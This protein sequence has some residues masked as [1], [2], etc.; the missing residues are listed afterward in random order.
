MAAPSVSIDLG[1]SFDFIT[2]PNFTAA[3]TSRILGPIGLKANAPFYLA[4]RPDNNIFAVRILEPDL[5]VSTALRDYVLT[6]HFD[7]IK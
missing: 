7:K 4:R 3:R 2:D 5:T 6:L 1:Q